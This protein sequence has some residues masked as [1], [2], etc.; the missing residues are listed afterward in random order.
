[1]NNKLFFFYFLSFCLVN[2]SCRKRPVVVSEKPVAPTLTCEVE[3]LDFVY[4]NSK[5]KFHYHD[6]NTDHKANINIRIKKDSI[7]WMSINAAA[8]LEA[9][10]IRAKTDSIWIIDRIKDTVLVYDYQTLS[11]EMGVPLSYIIIQNMVLGN[12]MFPKE[13]E[14]VVSHSDSIYCVFKQFKGKAMIV[15]KVKSGIRK[16][17]N[18]VV[19]DGR[20]NLAINYLKFVPLANNSFPLENEIVLTYKNGQGEN[21]NININIEHNKTEFPEKDLNFPF[22]IPNRFLKR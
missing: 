12:L 1:M 3:N 21:E 14:D 7:V 22:N 20:N 16:V 17:E 2:I 18:V 6:K 9:F 10:R 8:G 5:G 19:N 11:R 13:E 4:L 15:N